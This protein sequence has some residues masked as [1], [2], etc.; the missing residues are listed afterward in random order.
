MRPVS[1]IHIFSLT[2]LA[3]HVA[4]PFPSHVILYYKQIWTH[5]V[6]AKQLLQPV[7]T[8]H[9]PRFLGIRKPP[10]I[11]DWW[12]NNLIQLIKIQ[13]TQSGSPDQY[14]DRIPSDPDHGQLIRF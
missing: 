3:A 10:A 4:V 11:T 5:P 6:Q 8:H 1:L 14:Q 9:L 7:H 13:I 12:F 2:A